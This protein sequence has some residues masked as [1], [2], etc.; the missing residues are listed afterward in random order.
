VKAIDEDIYIYY[1]GITGSITNST[2]SIKY[3]EK[4][5][6]LEKNRVQWL[7]TFDV[8]DIYCANRI[9]YIFN[10]HFKKL[11]NVNKSDVNKAIEILY[12]IYKMYLPNIHFESQKLQKF[13]DLAYE[14][15]MKQIYEKLVVGNKK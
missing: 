13:V 7:K 1:S 8:F 12:E 3:F 5:L 4:L 6:A 15:N 2:H 11:A 9:E 10:N 14:G